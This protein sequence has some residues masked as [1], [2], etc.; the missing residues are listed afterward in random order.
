MY[1]TPIFRQTDTQDA[2]AF[3]RA[4]AFGVLA[5]S[6]EG[7][8][9]LSHVPFLLA[10]DGASADMHLLRSNPICTATGP[11][12]LMVYGPDGYLS[13][14]WY[15][16]DAQVPTWNYSAVH[17]T[18]RLERLPDDVLPEMLDRQSAFFEER[19]RPKAPWT[20]DK[21]PSDAAA[22][23]M[24]MILPFRLHVG[25]VQSVF[26]LSQNKPDDVRL[27]AADRV[28]EGFGLGLDALAPMMRD[29]K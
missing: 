9:I 11:V 25:D 20:M 3:A 15:E 5:A 14:D 23:M 4:R 13:P 27:R 1:P 12:T 6:T 19:L 17:L 24:R 28:G 16:V 10:E 21:M 8:P 29:A 2:L 26:K 22:R 18:G 7:A